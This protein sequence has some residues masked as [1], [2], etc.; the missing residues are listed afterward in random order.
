M[1]HTETTQNLHEN[2]KQPT[3][4]IDISKKEL[5]ERLK[6]KKIPLTDIIK[7]VKKHGTVSYLYD[8][9]ET[10][11]NYWWEHIEM[12]EK[13]WFIYKGKRDMPRWIV[14]KYLTFKMEGNWA[15]IYLN[16]VRWS[17]AKWYAHIKT[18]RIN[19]FAEFIHSEKSNYQNSWNNDINHINQ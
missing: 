10:D 7:E 19:E 9:S 6:E 11:V 4:T 8:S 16:E 13:L 18:L 12:D 1:N 3:N 5:F 17:S 15:Y 14:Y 2:L